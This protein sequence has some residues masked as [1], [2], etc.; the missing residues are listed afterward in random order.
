M[1]F[2]AVL[3]IIFLYRNWMG[4]NPLRSRVPF[5]RYVAW[6]RQR[7]VVANVRYVLCVGLPVALAL[8]ISLYLDDLFL[9]VLWL[10][11]ALAVLVYSVDIYDE[12]LAFEEHVEWL[13]SLGADDDLS[14][15]NWREQEFRL[16]TTYE[17]FQSLYPSL[18]WFLVL[19]PAPALAYILSR[20]YLDHLEDEDPELRLVGQVVYW[21]EWPAARLTGIVF[22]LLG[23]FGQCFEEWISTLTDTRES[24][25]VVLV[26]LA[27]AALGEHGKPG[28]GVEGMAVF[29]SQSE[30]ANDELRG[31]M[32]RTLFGW[33]G[34]AAVV[35][36]L[37]L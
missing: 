7:G 8:F 28:E 6:F 14:A 3:I 30:A 13:H 21:M 20:Q 17:I 23:H 16:V 15:A 29:T 33:L 35:A 32:D 5:G 4:G 26:R 2:L 19:G 18:F 1:K 27:S 12:D 22:A 24:I 9:G 10:V 25:G 36:I 37:G 11:F 31:L 34:V